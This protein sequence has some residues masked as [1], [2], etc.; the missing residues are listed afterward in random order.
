ME[1]QVAP[2]SPAEPA[3]PRCPNCGSPAEAHSYCADCGQRQAEFRQPVHMLARAL[4]AEYFGFEGKLWRTAVALLRPGFLT[5]EYLSGR[6][7]RYARPLRLYLTASLLFFFAVTLLDPGERLRQQILGGSDAANVEMTV[8]EALGENEAEMSRL[9]ERQAALQALDAAGIALVPDSLHTAAPDSARGL[10]V[11]GREWESG[12]IREFG[13]INSRED[14]ARVLPGFVQSAI[15]RV[16]N[17]MFVLLPA[18]AFLLKMLYARRQ[19]YYGEHLVFAFHVHAFWFGCFTLAVVLGALLGDIPGV[20]IYS[21]GQEAAA[22]GWNGAAADVLSGGLLI[23]LPLYT[24]LA[25]R[26]VYGQTWGKTLLKAW[27]LLWGYGAV[28]IAGL[29]TVVAL[30]LLW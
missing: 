15:A 8:R 18:F 11:A 30:T 17:A 22:A 12:R 6:Q 3:A 25:M 27:V 24:V 10:V 13:R 20:R 28:L 14:A 4:V 9:A 26:R 21:D 23:G 5:A 1:P 16:P 7:R 2:P 29:A 19:R